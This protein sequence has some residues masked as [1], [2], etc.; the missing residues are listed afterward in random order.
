MTAWIDDEGP[1]RRRDPRTQVRLDCMLTR[2][3]GSPVV[4]H[5]IDVGPSGMC[6]ET[7]RP[8]GVDEVLHFDLPVQGAHVDGDARVVRDQGRNVYAL[9]FVTMPHDTALQLDTLTS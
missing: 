3:R 8:L 9:R 6:V 5:T 4:C 7:E 2:R 1:C